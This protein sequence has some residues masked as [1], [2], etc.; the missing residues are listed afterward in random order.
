MKVEYNE[1]TYRGDGV[2]GRVFR[3]QYAA[4]HHP[5]SP[6]QVFI[7]PIT[8]QL[9]FPDAPPIT[10]P[11]MAFPPIVAPPPNQ[12]GHRPLPPTVYNSPPVI[13]P[14]VMAEQKKENIK[15]A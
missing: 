12:R 1:K 6:V 4:N 14:P 3:S 15:A 5:P 11:P 13:H 2:H 7:P 10:L 9:P 8:L